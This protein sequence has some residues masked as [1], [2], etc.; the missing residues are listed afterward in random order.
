MVAPLHVNWMAIRDGV[1]GPCVKSNLA[2]KL[3][4]NRNKDHMRTMVP[5]IC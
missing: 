4:N 5:K 2:L 1:L 3:P